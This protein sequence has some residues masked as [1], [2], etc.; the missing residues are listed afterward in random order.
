MSVGCRLPVL[1]NSPPNPKPFA[2]GARVWLRSC[3]DG[4]P[5]TVRGMRFGK[6][7][8]YWPSLHYTG[9][10]RPATLE[11]ADTTNQQCPVIASGRP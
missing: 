2:V 8:V 3:P 10:H 11:M 1:R 7:E 9:K 4:E 5:G 6:V